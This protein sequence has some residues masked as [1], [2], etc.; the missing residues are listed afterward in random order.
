MD[1]RLRRLEHEGEGPEDRARLIREK[2]RS[3]KITREQINLAAFLGDQD[4]RDALGK[5][6]SAEDAIDTKFRNSFEFSEWMGKL[7]SKNSE[8]GLRAMAVSI[9]LVLPTLEEIVESDAPRGTLQAFKRWILD[10]S[11]ENYQELFDDC[12]EVKLI[13]DDLHQND[14]RI[15]SI[16]TQDE[17]NSSLAATILEAMDRLHTKRDHPAACISM[18]N[19][20]DALSMLKHGPQYFI[21]LGEEVKGHWQATLDEHGEASTSEILAEIQKQLIPWVYGESDPLKQED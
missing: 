7:A 6:I 21:D 1:P 13:K 4:S 15:Q 9:E 19:I 20:A 18:A 8:A 5:E 3:G 14:R 12:I 17:Y 2:L 10:Q 11:P 16:R